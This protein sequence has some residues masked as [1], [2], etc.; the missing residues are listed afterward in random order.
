MTRNRVIVSLIVLVVG[1]IFVADPVVVASDHAPT[2]ATTSPQQLT[3][4]R[5]LTTSTLAS[6]DKSGNEV[7]AI[8]TQNRPAGV[9]SPPWR[10]PVVNLNY[11]GGPVMSNPIRVYFIWYEDRSLLNELDFIF[12]SCF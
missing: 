1:I 9:N 8:S 2:V 4:T 11:F 7:R 5:S 3:A 6:H 12:I 10:P